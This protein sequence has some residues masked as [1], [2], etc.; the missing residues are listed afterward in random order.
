MTHILV[1]GIFEVCLSEQGTAGFG[2]GQKN[3]RN[4]WLPVA[5]QTG[6][7]T[8]CVDWASKARFAPEDAPRN[9]ET[10][11]DTFSAH[12]FRSP[13]MCL[14]A[15]QPRSG[16]YCPIA[17]DAA[18]GSRSGTRSPTCLA[19]PL[20]TIRQVMAATNHHASRKKASPRE[21]CNPKP[22][23]IVRQRLERSGGQQC[24]YLAVADE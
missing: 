22:G 1:E 24:K 5:T 18:P 8:W 4:R 11:P 9:R 13:P 23:R 3:V 21:C 19:A 20:A 10:V 17:A 15:A 12:L 14:A 16:S 2:K 7:N 6:P